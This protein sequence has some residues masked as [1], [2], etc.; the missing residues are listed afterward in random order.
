MSVRARAPDAR[1][2]LL[3]LRPGAENPSGR[4]EEIACLG[5]R[6]PSRPESLTAPAAADPSE[7]AETHHRRECRLMPIVH[8]EFTVYWAMVFLSTSKTRGTTLWPYREPPRSCRSACGLAIGSPIA[9]VSA[10]CWRRGTSRSSVTLMTATVSAATRPHAVRQCDADRLWNRPGRL[11][12][13]APGPAAG[14]L[15]RTQSRSS[16]D[17]CRSRPVRWSARR[18]GAPAAMSW[19]RIASQL[20]SL[21]NRVKA[22]VRPTVPRSG[23]EGE[24]AR[25]GPQRP[26][27]YGVLDDDGEDR[28]RRSDP[29]AGDEHPE[30]QGRSGVSAR[31]LVI[32]VTPPAAS[33]SAPAAATCSDRCGS[34]PGR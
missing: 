3:R 26:E 28:H 16:A 27:R 10:S 12:G 20:R 2:G 21:R 15:A 19:V 23:E 18:A 5:R 24:V 22:N 34:R 1:R 8:M 7:H 25:R 33:A 29:D 17:R 14:S 31:R 30:P 11:A 32:S 13:T 4:A 9:S 6:L